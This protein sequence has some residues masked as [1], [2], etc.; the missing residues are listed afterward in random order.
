MRRLKDAS[1]NQLP[2]IEPL[3]VKD[4]VVPP[5]ATCDRCYTYLGRYVCYNDELM[6]DPVKGVERPIELPCAVA[7]DTSFCSYTQ[8]ALKKEYDK[9][10]QFDRFMNIAEVV[11]AFVAFVACAVIF[12]FMVIDMMGKNEASEFV[13]TLLMS[14]VIVV[15]MIGAFAAF[16][17]LLKKNVQHGFQSKDVAYMRD[18]LIKG[19]ALIDPKAARTA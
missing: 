17:V 8:D 10:V 3:Q 2:N 12:G 9:R 1:V 11:A 5:C 13:L 18:N 14:I 19:G 6:Y 15:V 7:R 4:D 16:L